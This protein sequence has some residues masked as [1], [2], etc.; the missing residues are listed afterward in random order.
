MAGTGVAETREAMAK[1]AQSVRLSRLAMMPGCSDNVKGEVG[2]NGGGRKGC[3]YTTSHKQRCTR[4]HLAGAALQSRESAFVR[5]C[6]QCFGC[7]HGGVKE[8]V[9]T[10]LAA[11]VRQKSEDRHGMLSGGGAVY[12]RARPRERMWRRR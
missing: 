2:R 3:F 7:I 8:L 6:P 9:S 1:V 5:V 11:D 10:C 12:H 4:L